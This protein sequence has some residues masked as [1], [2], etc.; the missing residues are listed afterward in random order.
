MGTTLAAC[1]SMFNPTRSEVQIRTNPEHARCEL[2]G[3]DGF[4]AV[5]ET[6]T[7]ID[8]PHSA[9]PVTVACDA[10]GFRRTVSSLNAAS[11][12]WIWANSALLMATGGV[13]A[14]GL[15]VDEALGSDW[16]YKKDM[17]VELDAERK[18]PLR[19]K[20]RDGAQDLRLQ[21]R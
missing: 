21:A 8:I 6:P 2:T 18:R 12:G 14:L 7:T 3:R 16:T 10:P 17:S 9:A 13:A 15:V 20:S 11:S 19:A 4:S 1:A 5:I